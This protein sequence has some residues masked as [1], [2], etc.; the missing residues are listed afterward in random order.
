[1]Y[2]LLACTPPKRWELRL[3][4]DL[5]Q[6]SC[7]VRLLWGERDDVIYRPADLLIAQMREV[8]GELDL[9]RIPQAGHWS[10]YEHATLVHRLLLEFFTMEVGL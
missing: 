3:L 4:S 8:V 2:G 10:A 9:Y 1:V 5:S 6:L 7:R